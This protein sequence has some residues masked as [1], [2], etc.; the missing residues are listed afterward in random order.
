MRSE[1]EAMKNARIFAATGRDQRTCAQ[2]K[3]R[4]WSIFNPEGGD[5]HCEDLGEVKDEK[6][7]AL[8]VDKQ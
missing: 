4:K 2:M 5:L 3:E 6:D 8:L 7:T 1:F